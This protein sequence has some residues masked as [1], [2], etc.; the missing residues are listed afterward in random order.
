MII[1]LIVALAMV[2][3]FT[4]APFVIYAFYRMDGGKQS[5]KQ[6]YKGVF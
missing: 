5:I 2:A 6:F 3:A 4:V 1:F